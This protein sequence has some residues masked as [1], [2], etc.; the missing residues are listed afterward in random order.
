MDMPDEPIAKVQMQTDAAR[1]PGGHSRETVL[2]ECWKPT[3]S[4][5]ETVVV[6][7]IGEVGAPLC[8]LISRRNKVI[9]I[10]VLSP[11]TEI[12]GVDVLHICY[13]FQIENFVDETAHYI[14]LFRPGLTIINSTVAVGTTRTIARRTC[15]AV[16]Y[17]PIRGKHVRMREELLRYVKF[18][19]AIDSVT[20]LRTAMH[21]ELIGMRTRIL[22]SP[23]A[24]ELAKLAETTYFGLLIAFA[25]EIE[26]DCDK[27]HLNYDEVVAF[28]EEIG[29]LPSVKYFPGIIGGHCVMPNIELLRQLDG[30]EILDAIQSSNKKKIEREAATSTPN[31][32]CSGDT[33]RGAVFAKAGSPHGS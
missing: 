29:Y 13:P 5:A 26:R 17:S 28:F 9:G 16:A 6:V 23:E 14:R 22:S 3:M 1:N 31:D 18:V 8:E 20:A 15:G 30:S 4:G 33:A 11:P 24:T 12:E 21:F 7:G 27:L 25:Q 10:D 19:G 32:G 2:P